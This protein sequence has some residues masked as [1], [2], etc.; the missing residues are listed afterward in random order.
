MAN[1][2]EGRKSYFKYL[3]SINKVEEYDFFGMSGICKE[4]H[5]KSIKDLS[6]LDPKEYTIHEDLKI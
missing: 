4:V 2:E 6:S 3:L 5:V 1:A